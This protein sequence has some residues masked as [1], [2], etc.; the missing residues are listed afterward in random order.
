[1]T[2]KIEKISPKIYK[3]TDNDKHLGTISTYHNL[4]HNKYIYLKFN[5]RFFIKKWFYL[6]TTLLY[7]YR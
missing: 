3:V 4:F 2:T 7:A 6:Q 1:M 5:R